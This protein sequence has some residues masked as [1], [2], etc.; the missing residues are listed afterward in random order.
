MGEAESNDRSGA[1]FVHV[2]DTI[3]EDSGPIEGSAEEGGEGPALWLTHVQR[4]LLAAGRKYQQAAPNEV[5]TLEDAPPTLETTV[6]MQRPVY[7]RSR[8]HPNEDDD[9]AHA[10]KERLSGA[11]R[12][13]DG[14][15]PPSSSKSTSTGDSPGR[16]E[17]LKEE[18]LSEPS[19]ATPTVLPVNGATTTAAE[20]D[21]KT[22]IV[23]TGTPV[24]EPHRSTNIPGEKRSSGYGT[25]TPPPRLTLGQVMARS[26]PS[27]SVSSRVATGAPLPSTTESERGR[28]GRS[29][30][31]LLSTWSHRNTLTLDPSVRPL[32]RRPTEGSLWPTSRGVED[33]NA[34]RNT[35]HRR[36]L[37]LLQ[38]KSGPGM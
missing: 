13:D 6:Q 27:P 33:S 3:G 9:D 34:R 8:A 31:A 28:R 32:G 20:V 15:E 30:A 19:I 16:E 22:N 25:P 29:F 2:M 21:S 38:W 37:P 12:D 36:R 24:G 1:A 4:Y 18:P 10:H 5:G 23:T 11:G 7:R 17:G 35:A 14:T 26:L